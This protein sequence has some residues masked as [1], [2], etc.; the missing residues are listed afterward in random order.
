M[1]KTKTVKT[2]KPKH[3]QTSKV[4]NVKIETEPNNVVHTSAETLDEVGKMFIKR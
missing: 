1:T 3:I 4:D 2:D